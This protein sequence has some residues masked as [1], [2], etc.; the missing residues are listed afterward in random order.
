M[1]AIFKEQ[2]PVQEFYHEARHLT[3]RWRDGSES[4]FDSMWLRDNCPED[5]DPR[6]GQRCV[7]ISELPPDPRIGGV[8]YVGNGILEIIWAGELKHSRFQLQWL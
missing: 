7:D 1:N 2:L 4:R 8:S 3:V 6:N 5:R